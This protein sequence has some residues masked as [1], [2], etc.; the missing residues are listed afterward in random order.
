RD[1]MEVIEYSSYLEYDKIEIAKHYLIP[2]ELD[3]NGLKGLKVKMQKS[4]LEE[5]IRYYV[6]EAGVR[7]LQ[8]KI[9]SIF[10]KIAKEVASGSTKSYNITAD[11]VKDYLGQRKMISEIANRKP[12][13]G[14]TTGLAWTQYGGEIMFC[15]A[16]RMPG[17]GAVVITGLLG[18]VMKESAKIAVSYLKSNHTKYNIDPKD[19][20]SYDI[21]IHFPSGAVP[22]DGPSAGVTLTTTLA[23]LFTQQQ[24]K[25]NVAM[26]GEMTLLGKV[27]PIG[28]IKEKLLAA[29]RAGIFSVLLPLENKEDISEL[30]ADILDGM[31]LSYVDEVTQVLEKVLLPE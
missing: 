14:I 11:N 5:L 12:E 17:K 18:E 7:N 30:E 15:E 19:F 16:I 31:E 27:L 8:R 3:A 10:R 22:K 24:V 21:H 9:G 26:T 28:G 23:S 29:K 4:A 25:H 20:E 13:I 6:R 1:R 2:K